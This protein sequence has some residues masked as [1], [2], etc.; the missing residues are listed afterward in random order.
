MHSVGRSLYLKQLTIDLERDAAITNDKC[1][2]SISNQLN[3]Y[4]IQ[5][6]TDYVTAYYFDVLKVSAPGRST[7]R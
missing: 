4:P 6:D 1:G 3:Q 2:M 5:E 7:F